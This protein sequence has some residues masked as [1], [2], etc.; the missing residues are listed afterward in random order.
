MS[1]TNG[2][3]Q[4]TVSMI[5]QRLIAK[6]AS[7]ADTLSALL[8]CN[9]RRLHVDTIRQLQRDLMTAHHLLNIFAE[10]DEP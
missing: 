2:T 4:V 9:D 10:E 3:P 6:A 8:A 1:T 5:R 7:I